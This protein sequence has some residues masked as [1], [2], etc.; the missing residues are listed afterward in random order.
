[1]KPIMQIKPYQTDLAEV[2]LLWMEEYNL[3]LLVELYEAQKLQEYLDKQVE[4]AEQ[5][6]QLLLKAGRPR[7]YAEEE[8]IGIMLAPPRDYEPKW[9]KE[10]LRK[11]PEIEN[12]LKI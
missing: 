5:Q 8:V 9:P 4:W 7:P 1:M 6:I 12:S 2:H 3:N 10:L 11:I